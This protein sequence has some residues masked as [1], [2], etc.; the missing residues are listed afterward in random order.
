ML[1]KIVNQKTKS[2]SSS[3]GLEGLIEAARV[4]VRAHALR[5]DDKASDDD[6]SDA[7]ADLERCLPRQRNRTPG[8]S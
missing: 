4:V 3:S 7:I 6:V 1:G 8:R 5:D 2:H